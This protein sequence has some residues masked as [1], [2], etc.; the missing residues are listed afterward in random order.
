MARRYAPRPREQRRAV[1][2]G[3]NA[4]PACAGSGCV[5]RCGGGRRGVAKW[6]R[7]RASSSMR[8]SSMTILGRWLTDALE[9]FARVVAPM[10]AHATRSRSS[11]GP[12][13]AVFSVA[14]RDAERAVGSEARHADVRSA[15][16]RGSE[17][18]RARW[19]AAERRRA[20]ATAGTKRPL[21]A[22]HRD[23]GRA[24]ADRIL[25]RRRSSRRLLGDARGRGAREPRR[26]H[27]HDGATQNPRARSSP[28]KRGSSSA[29][30]LRS[31]VQSDRPAPRQSSS[32][33]H[34]TPQTS[35]IGSQ[36]SGALPHVP[37]APG[38]HGRP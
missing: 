28:A 10:G 16:R 21:G 36:A 13:L 31:H 11:R 18:A 5:R 35:K 12:V 6:S 30:G 4:A 27:G 17:L 38:M 29:R 32:P 37:V 22:R 34:A 2:S 33:S 20:T 15:I 24:R 3:W 1:A 9:V 25:A 26:P 14:A 23:H 8:S 19:E 7:S